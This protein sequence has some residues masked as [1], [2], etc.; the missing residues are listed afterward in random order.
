MEMIHLLYLWKADSEL[1]DQSQK[2]SKKTTISQLQSSV[3]SWG[4]HVFKSTLIDHL[5]AN[6]YVRKKCFGH[7]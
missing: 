6:R 5:H 3:A 1:D 2:M 4:H 7:N